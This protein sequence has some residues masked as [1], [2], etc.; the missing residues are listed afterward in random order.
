MKINF[1]KKQFKHLL[2]LVHLGE[3]TA[4]SSRNPEQLIKEY[5]E[6]YQY[7]NS[8]AKDFGY[9][10]IITFERDHNEYY[11]T[12]AYENQLQPIIDVNDNDVFWNE[13]SSR[14]AERDLAN[15][16]V[17]PRDKDER[18]KRLLEIEERYE[19]EFEEN[20]LARLVVRED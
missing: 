2:D 15:E 19:E 16:A 10:D 12:Q 13:L 11:P 18:F 1:T 3:W 8:F 20:G 4:N 9:D 5:E 6:L 14:L 7:I 17:V